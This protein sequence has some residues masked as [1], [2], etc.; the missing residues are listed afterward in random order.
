MELFVNNE[1]V[2]SDDI[3]EF[4][5]FEFGR[6]CHKW[7]TMISGLVP[8]NTIKLELRYSLSRDLFDGKDHFDEGDYHLIIEASVQ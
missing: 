5:E 7:V 8:G 6:P 4:D 3:V 1:V 2:N